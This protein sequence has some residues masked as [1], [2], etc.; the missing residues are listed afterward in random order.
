[1]VY[2]QVTL[3]EQ[4]SM[5]D[6]RWFLLVL[7]YEEME[8]V[9]GMGEQVWTCQR[10]GLLSQLQHLTE[11]YAQAWEAPTIGFIGMYVGSGVFREMRITAVDGDVPPG[12][13][14]KVYRRLELAWAYAEDGEEPPG[15]GFTQTLDIER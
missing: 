12:L 7:N 4:A 10:E 6:D 2:E 5:E 13:E 9:P 14:G 15:L 8:N 1:M 11:A 3:D